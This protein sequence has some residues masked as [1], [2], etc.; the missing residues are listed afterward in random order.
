MPDEREY[1]YGIIVL[2]PYPATTFMSAAATAAATKSS[3]TKSTS[4][5]TATT[6]T[7]EITTAATTWHLLRKVG[8]LLCH[9]TTLSTVITWTAATWIAKSLSGRVVRRGAALTGKSLSHVIVW[10]CI[11]LSYVVSRLA[12]ALSYVIVWPGK[13]LPYVVAR[14][15]ITLSYIII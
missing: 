13:S 11:S 4:A 8:L 1:L 10:P 15:V 2:V 12:I 6:T 14:L 7:A 9:H 3:S 5:N